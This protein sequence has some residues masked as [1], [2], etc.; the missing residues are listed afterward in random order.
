MSK[1]V[2]FT[3]LSFFFLLVGLASNSCYA[4]FEGIISFEQKTAKDT[5]LCNIYVKEP[6]VKYEE[7]FTNG[8][9]KRYIVADLTKGE[10][11]T[12]YPSQNLVEHKKLPK[13]P[14]NSVFT[15]EKKNNTKNIKGI[16][17]QQWI[18]KNDTQQDMMLFY[19]YKGKYSFYHKM[20]PILVHFSDMF[21]YF[22]AIKNNQGYMPMGIKKTDRLWKNLKE[23]KLL[24]I[25]E[26]TIPSN[27]FDV[28]RK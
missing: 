3:T 10:S 20:A 7:V 17:C 19:V 16:I 27:N 26:Q 22:S 13:I 1:P 4:Q 25:N 15:I 12:V 23:L 18:V 8:S 11:A 2:F 21:H 5:L 14:N 9:I 6:L 24:A 28:P